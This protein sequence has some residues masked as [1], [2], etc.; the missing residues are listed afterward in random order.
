ML[1]LTSAMSTA[2]NPTTNIV[3]NPTCTVKDTTSIVLLNFLISY[4]L[5]VTLILSSTPRTQTVSAIHAS[6]CSL[7]SLVTPNDYSVLR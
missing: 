2:V 1:P 7:R 4:L 5:F 3:V 6:R